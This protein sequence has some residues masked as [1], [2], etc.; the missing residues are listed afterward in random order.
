MSLDNPISLVYNALAEM[1]TCNKH[2]QELVREGNLI[3]FCGKDD[4]VN[5]S[6]AKVASGVAN[7]NTD[8]PE[9]RIIPRGSTPHIQNTSHT[10]FLTVRFEIQMSTGTYNLD[11]VLFPVQWAV[12]RAMANWFVVVSQLKW[13]DRNFVHLT[14]PVSGQDVISDTD[15]ARGIVGWASLWACE[16]T[17]DFKTIDLLQ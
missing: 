6:I 17:M 15:L 2:F 3:R 10:S 13:K 11:K 9:V 4:E 8:L 1:L 16:I 12:Y 7:T 5:R 14:R